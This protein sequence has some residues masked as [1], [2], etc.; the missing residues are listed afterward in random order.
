MSAEATANLR[1]ARAVTPALPVASVRQT[2]FVRHAQPTRAQLRY[3]RAVLLADLKAACESAWKPTAKADTHSVCADALDTEVSSWSD[4]QNSA[5]GVEAFVEVTALW[6]QWWNE[7]DEQ[8]A[9]TLAAE[10]AGRAAYSEARE[11]YMRQFAGRRPTYDVA[12]VAE[13]MSGVDSAYDEWS[14][15]ALVSEEQW[16][17][18]KSAF[19]SGWQYAV[20]SI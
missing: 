17:A 8:H 5:I 9:L 14:F 7:L 13:Q 4:A 15:R 18:I 6:H 11:Q 12:E 16:S 1:G 2:K 10:K 3:Q 19:R 20:D